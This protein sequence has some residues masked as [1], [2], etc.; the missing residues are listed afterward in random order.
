[1]HH[2]NDIIIRRCHVI[3]RMSKS[4]CTMAKLVSNGILVVGTYIQ[5]NITI[6]LVKIH[7]TQSSITGIIYKENIMIIDSLNVV[8][9]MPVW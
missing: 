7:K 2:I 1:M 6:P 9:P 5:V 8:L 4:K 3:V